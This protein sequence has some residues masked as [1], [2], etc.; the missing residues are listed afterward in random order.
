MD[1]DICGPSIP[2]V[3]GLTGAQVHASGAGW[4]P[5]YVADNLCAMSVGF[6]LPRASDAVMWR[7][8]RKN[9][10][11]AQFLKDVDW[12]ALDFLLVAAEPALRSG[13]QRHVRAQ[14]T[15]EHYGAE[16]DAGG[17]NEDALGEGGDRGAVDDPEK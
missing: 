13:A 7:G 12:G 6:L 15:Q 10:L 1:I 5:V 14:E 2:T 11:I 4:S 9:G 16:G 17:G 8:P 3:L